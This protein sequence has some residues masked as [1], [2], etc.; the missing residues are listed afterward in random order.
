MGM[1]MISKGV[2]CALDALVAVFPDADVLALSGNMCTGKCS[3]QARDQYSIFIV[4][5]SFSVF[6]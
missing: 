3:R 6:V 5:F 4:L 2:E 1:N